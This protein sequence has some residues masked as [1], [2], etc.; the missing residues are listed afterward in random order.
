M[1]AL[2]GSL[3]MT[4]DKYFWDGIEFLLTFSVLLLTSQ[5]LCHF[6]VISVYYETPYILKAG[7]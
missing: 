1:L 7:C 5:N 4:Q 3:E 2:L 6:C